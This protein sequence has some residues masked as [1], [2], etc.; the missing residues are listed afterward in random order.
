MS[1]RIYWAVE[2]IGVAPEQSTAAAIVA[3]GDIAGAAGTGPDFVPGVQ[4]VGITTN[5]NLEQ[6]FQLGQLEIYED[7]EDVPDIEI[8]VEKVFDQY[9]P[10]YARAIRPEGL[11]AQNTT[12]RNIA[13]CQNNE[14]DIYFTVNSDQ[15]EAVAKGNHD[16]FV[17][18]SGMF[19]SS[20]SF[21]FATDGYFTESVTLVGNHKQW[22]TAPGANKMTG[23][24]TGN[25]NDDTGQVKQRQ[26][27]YFITEPATVGATVDAE[28]AISSVTVSTDFGREEMNVLGQKLPYHRYVT[29]P[30]E[31]T[32][33]IE[34]Y[35]T[36][37]S[38]QAGGNR[39][40]AFP[41]K[42]NLTEE[43]IKIGVANSDVQD[44][45]SLGG[46]HLLHTID[47]GTKNK[48]QSITWGGGDTGGSN[49]TLTLSY[50]NFNKMD[51]KYDGPATAAGLY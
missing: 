32:C 8:T 41:N 11:P 1:K 34:M 40:D 30:I 10:F 42:T 36:R 50:R 37:I 22:V 13:D 49:A 3:A 45:N 35:V 18:C 5:F 12:K 39:L 19:V 26:N 28:T 27:F 17:F 25:I 33:D 44:I 24:P 46:A 31:V 2:A 4:S 16:A 14:C 20:D 38:T 23:V 21:N 9:L 29:F 6:I 15:D 7:L 51:Y 47:L 43:S 48:I